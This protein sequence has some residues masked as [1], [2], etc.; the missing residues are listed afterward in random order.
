MMRGAALLLI[1]APVVPAQI[2][3]SAPQLALEAT[4]PKGWRIDN[5]STSQSL[6]LRRGK[7]RQPAL[8]AFWP[9]PERG[10]QPPSELF[11]LVAGLIGGDERFHRAGPNQPLPEAAKG[12]VGRSGSFIEASS[13]DGVLLS[14]FIHL[15]NPGGSAHVFWLTATKSAMRK[16]WPEA[17]GFIH[18][19]RFAPPAQPRPG[20]AG[21][22]KD[23]TNSPPIAVWRDAT[24][25]LY[26]TSYPTGFIQAPGTGSDLD[27]AGLRLEPESDAERERASITLSRQVVAPHITVRSHMQQLLD[28][29]DKDESVVSFSYTPALVAGRSAWKVDWSRGEGVTTT[30]HSLWL[31]QRERSIFSVEWVG[32]PQWKKEHSGLLRSFAKALGL[33]PGD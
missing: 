10:E 29:L 6:V 18:G 32:D 3:I 19:S 26:M 17:L 33:P 27:G 1:M 23:D 25:G 5:I 4:T 20:S 14:R 21:G 13:E 22:Q 12:S 7:G 31:F 28:G 30:G 8:R 15:P 11:S 16:A 9:N 24:S 2:P